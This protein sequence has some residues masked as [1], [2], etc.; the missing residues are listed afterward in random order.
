MRRG[1]TGA[2]GVSLADLIARAADGD[3][4][5]VPDG[6]APG[7]GPVRIRRSVRLVSTIGAVVPD[8][9]VVS[10][11]AALAMSG[12]TGTG[13]LTASPGARVIANDCRFTS[14]PGRSSVIA[15]GTGSVLDFTE[16]RFTGG[17]AGA[18][19]L[20]KGAA[21][22]LT[23]CDF[24]SFQAPAVAV[25]DPGTSVDV[26]DCR[27]A[28][29]TGHAVMAE[30]GATAR[31][32]GCS[33][34]HYL[35]DR[36][37]AVIAV[38]S[39]SD[40][41]VTGC[42][43]GPMT[44]HGVFVRG[45]GRARVDNCDF[46]GSG[47]LAAVIAL[48]DHSDLDVSSCRFVGSTGRGVEVA[49][50]AAA[51]ISD[52]DLQADG[53]LAPVYAEGPGS[54]ASL[55]G[56]R[57]SSA[58]ALGAAAAG[59]AELDVR[60][61][62]FDC[63]GATGLADGA[64]GLGR[65]G[66]RLRITGACSLRGATVTITGTLNHTEA[67]AGTAVTLTTDFGTPC[68][69]CNGSGGRPGISLTACARCGGRGCRAQTSSGSPGGSPQHLPGSH[70][71]FAADCPDCRGSGLSSDDPCTECDGRGGHSLERTL[72]VNVPA[73]VRTGQTLIATGHG[74]GGLGS[75]APG[76]LHIVLS[77]ADPPFRTVEEYFQK[78]LG[79][80]VAAPATAPDAARRELDE[81]VRR[82]AIRLGYLPADGGGDG[83]KPI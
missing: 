33:F 48:D 49:D 52:C 4:V 16:C 22:R 26:T 47:E 14:A 5:T 15:T 55:T 69:Q 71:R 79:V 18:V 72:Q 50:G 73:G 6:L 43:F 78:A 9:I 46:V 62:S 32:A 7:S 60:E 34:D 81:A 38:G 24:A 75:G 10:G 29:T 66:S 51:R 12:I 31:V 37:T 8:D 2:T 25:S 1:Q 61:C 11:P 83:R 56:C 77:V 27:F 13:V 53:E 76:D 40:A 36:W 19:R 45:A 41:D 74:G 82:E 57:I 30:G 3:T 20:G 63:P 65:D 39:G 42:R 54:T 35:S 59:A 44:A 58:N 80:R 67:A 70:H 68:R 64:I 28:G 23:D 17:E 21:A